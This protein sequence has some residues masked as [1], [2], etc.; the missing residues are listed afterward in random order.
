M[1]KIPDSLLKNPELKPAADYYRLRREGIGFIQEMSS[2]LWTDYNAHDP[3]ITILESLCYAITDLAYRC[4]WRI[5]DLLTPATPPADSEQPFRDQAFFTAR[6]IL[7]INPVTPDDFRRLL[8]DLEDIRNAWVFCGDYACG[9]GYY[10][11][12]RND[13]MQLSYQSPDA[14][15]HPVKVEPQGLYEI[16]LELEADPEFG[17]LNDRK[18]RRVHGVFDSDGKAHPLT[19]ELHFPDWELMNPGQAALFLDSDDAFNGENG[20]GF[21]LKVLRFGATKTFDIFT[22]PSL[23]NDAERDNYLRRH[24]RNVLYLSFELELL[25]GGEKLT[26][27]NTA[28]RIFGDVFAKNQVT[29]LDMKTLFEDMTPAGFIQRYRNKRLKILDAIDKAKD[30]LQKYRNLDEDY[31]RVRAINIEDVSVCADIEVKPDADIERIQA[32][33][34]LIIERHFNPPV[35]FYTLQELLDG[36]TP[37]EDI[38]NG[39]ELNNGFIKTE[40]LQNSNLKTVLRT[41]DLI[42]SLMDIDGIIAVNNLLLT[43]YDA[44]G[45]IAKGAADP[46]WSADGRPLF[47]SNKISA[48]W[49]LFVSYLHQPRFHRELSRFLFFKNGLPFLPRQDEAYDTLIQRR[50]E[51]DRP[52]IKN[53]DNDLLVPEGR[54]RDP[55]TY[56]PLQ[57]G[58][59]LTYG[60]GSEGLPAQATSQRKAQARQLKAYLM[61]FEQLIAN[62]Q[63]QIAHV[64]DL[65]SLN[66]A[67]DRSYFVREFNES[68][69]AGYNDL[70]DALDAD[71]LLALAESTPEFHERRNR[72]LNHLMARFGEQFGEY[73]LLIS[74]SQ[75]Q[76]AAQDRLIEDKIAFLNAY[77][78]ISHDRGKAF[79][80]KQPFSPDD[81]SDPNHYNISRPGI[82]K[83]VGLLLGFPDLKFDRTVTGPSGG[84][85]AVAYQL[86]DSHQKTW[87]TG[88]LTSAASS[89]E[90][91]S[92]QAFRTV[93]VQM[94]RADAYQIVVEAQQFRVTLKDGNNNPLGQSALFNDK[95]QAEAL[96]AELLSWSANERSIVIEHLLLR[97]KFPGDALYPACVSGGC[98]TC[99]DEDPYSFR[100]TWVMPGWTA[101]YNDNLEMR[102]FADRTIAQET[103]AHLL[104]KICWLANDGF[105]N[106]PCS[107]VVNRLA[108]W[109]NTHALT[110]AA[111]KLDGQQAC[112]CT[113]ALYNRFSETFKAWYQDK[114]LQHFQPDVLKAQLQTLFSGLDANGLA[115]AAVFDVSLWQ[116]IQKLMLDYFQQIALNGWQFERF[117]A[118]W[119]DWLEANAQIDWMEERLQERLHAI[120][121]AN[122]LNASNADLCQ[123]S[124]DI[125][126]TY[127]MTFYQW[128]SDNIR[129]GNDLSNLSDFQS[130]AIVLREEGSDTEPGF[131]ID[132]TF[133]AGTSAAVQTLLNDRYTAY[134]N[135][136]YYLGL[137]VTLLA[138]LSN[139]Y[140]DATLHDCDDGSDQNPVRLGSTAL[141]SLHARRPSETL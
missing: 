128:M 104:A 48:S 66:P 56:F 57:Y 127:G 95:L 71:V 49:L 32:E 78:L 116:D 24:W 119:R 18:I 19:M 83:R 129:Q 38:F 30:T 102:G 33:I 28:L 45:H 61:I 12:C 7:T 76:A 120:L 6:T 92:R 93:I 103:P 122:L 134:R 75:G 105:I 37:V 11:W 110:A 55:E 65:F 82:K 117:E 87:F 51:L 2:R 98:I 68:I 73:A 34:W 106:N 9:T 31:Q 27:E 81:Y 20:A 70:I 64:A 86:A 125:L 39:P 135:V 91:A 79:N 3:G 41:S 44:E 100:L 112:D 101:P 118:A 96:Q 17:D 108:D 50:G 53:T 52:K 88:S 8:I 36:N 35:P 121:G 43:K 59:P 126:T 84:P 67:I 47:D 22:D 124:T 94:S 107:P 89:A 132:L 13:Q 138:N 16:L 25:P 140:P 123:C 90:T 85:Y 60:I 114:T 74:R 131:C 58:F 62:A 15:L 40:D 42:N 133:R 72:F 69:I 139:T 137:L 14:A 23:K 63:A 10:A 130:A 111:V 77:P 113:L 115:C 29:A 136:S 141:G 99:G 5:V 1:N 4:G 97:P 54:F 26:I 46:D 109:L 21:N 80:Y